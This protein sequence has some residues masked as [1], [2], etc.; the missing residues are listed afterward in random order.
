MYESLVYR[1]H[2]ETKVEHFQDESLVEVLAPWVE[3]IRTGSG[4]M[5]AFRAGQVR[6]EPPRSS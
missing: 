5:L 3:G 1:P 2:P 6:V 4:V